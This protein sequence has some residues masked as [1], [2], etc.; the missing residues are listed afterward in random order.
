MPLMF[1]LS[2]YVQGMKDY[3]TSSWLHWVKKS[4]VDL[5]LPCMLFSFAQ[6]LI[7]YFIFSRSNPANFVAVTI[8]EL[9][10]I[11]LEGLKEYWFLA[12]LFFI[13]VI[14][15]SFGCSSCPEKIY[16]AFWVI[17]FMFPLCAEKFLPVNISNGLYF[18]VGYILKRSDYISREKNLGVIAGLMLL[19]SGAIFFFVP[20]A[21]D[22]IN[23]FTGICAALCSC[24]GLFAMFYAMGVNYSWL[25]ICGLYSMV[26]YCLHNWITAC[27]RMIFTVTGLSSSSEPVIMF[28]ASFVHAMILPLLCVW[29]YKNV[30]GLRWIEYIFY[31]GKLIRK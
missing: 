27:F 13:K 1:M 23:I 21:S 20:Y 4:A 2:G 31:P 16:S 28:A 3:R 22:S 9:A 14:H 26:I 7:M 8:Q 25:V 6:W 12:A 5:Y 30:K 24:F 18:H 17:V 29:L 19:I 11:P 10:I 15:S